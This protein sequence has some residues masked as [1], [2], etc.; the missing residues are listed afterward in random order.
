MSKKQALKLIPIIF[1]SFFI[2]SCSGMQFENPLNKSNSIT[3]GGDGEDTDNYVTSFTSDFGDDVPLPS[4]L[5]IIRNQTFINQSQT[6]K[7]EGIISLKGKID[8]ESLIVFF[9][10]SMPGAGWVKKYSSRPGT[11][12]IIIFNKDN[13]RCIVNMVSEKTKTFATIWL[14]I[15]N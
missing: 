14:Y 8:I 9:E 12:A 15:Q 3:Q 4:T 6:L 5:E 2:V 1:L 7:A 13:R 11:K 10:E